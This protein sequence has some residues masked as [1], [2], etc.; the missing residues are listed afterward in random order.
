MNYRESDTDSDAGEKS[1]SVSM[2]NSGQPAREQLWWN[3]CEYYQ[4]SSE[5][6]LWNRM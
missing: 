3:D 1:H 5:R 2:M 4:S 6:R